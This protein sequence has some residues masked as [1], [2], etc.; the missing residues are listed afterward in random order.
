MGRKPVTDVLINRGDKDTD[1]YRRK[2]HMKTQGEDH[3]PA[4]ER[5]L[6]R[7]QACR[8]SDLRLLVC[9]VARKYISAV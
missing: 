8:H 1:T 6:R 4:T 3:L 2:D 7:D 9:G 5:V